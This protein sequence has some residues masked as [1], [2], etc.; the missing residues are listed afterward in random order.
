ME[1]IIVGRLLT[2]DIETVQS[3]TTVEEAAQKMSENNIP[4]VVTKNGGKVKSIFTSSDL[5]DAVSSGRD[6]SNILIKSYSSREVRTVHPQDSVYKATR[7]MYRHNISHLP[8]THDD[9]VLG[10]ISQTD[11][12]DY[13]SLVE[14]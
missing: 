9:V 10:I 12:S 3:D 14:E 11:V 1:D 4:S 7:I 5:N 2:S 8:V 6:P 13:L